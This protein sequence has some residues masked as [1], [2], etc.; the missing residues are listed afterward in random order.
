MN[1]V[2]LVDVFCGVI[3]GGSQERLGSIYIFEPAKIEQMKSIHQKSDQY[4]F[5]NVVTFSA[6]SDL[7]SSIKGERKAFFLGKNLY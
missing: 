1:F 5:E 6:E 4:N 2:G 7:I 3:G